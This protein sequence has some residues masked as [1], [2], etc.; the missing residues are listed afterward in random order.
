[1][2]GSDPVTGGGEC[3]LPG[4]AV[5]AVVVL[6]VLGLEDALQRGLVGGGALQLAEVLEPLHPAGKDDQDVGVR[7]GAAAKACTV[8]GGTTIR[9]PSPA[10]RTRSPVSISAA[11]E[12]T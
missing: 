4:R 11:A 3:L 9:S 5:V 2:A 7:I 8:P 1:M 12:M 6:A 10:V